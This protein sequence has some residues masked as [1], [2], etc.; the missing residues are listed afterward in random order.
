MSAEER[1]SSGSGSEPEPELGGSEQAEG[2]TPQVSAA[3]KLK[4]LRSLQQSSAKKGTPGCDK[5]AL[6][7]LRADLCHLWAGVLYLSRIPPAPGQGP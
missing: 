6:S 7:L 4:L 2:Q 5:T 1:E 3:A